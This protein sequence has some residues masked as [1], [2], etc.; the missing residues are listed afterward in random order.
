MSGLQDQYPCLFVFLGG[1]GGVVGGTSRRD[2]RTSGVGGGFLHDYTL[3][4][5]FRFRALAF[6]VER[7]GLRVQC[8]SVISSCCPNLAGSISGE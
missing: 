8:L 5:R 7:V 6:N 3:R 4:V 2:D 1:R